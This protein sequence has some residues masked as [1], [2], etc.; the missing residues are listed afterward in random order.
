MHQGLL[1]VEYSS[2]CND[3]AIRESDML[4][5]KHNKQKIKVQFMVIILIMLLLLLLLTTIII[6]IMAVTDSNTC[7]EEPNNTT[8]TKIG[9]LSS[10]CYSNIHI[11]S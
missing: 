7:L 4:G 6:M 10:E 5:L 9:K 1:S 8:A 2:L 11:L 3:C